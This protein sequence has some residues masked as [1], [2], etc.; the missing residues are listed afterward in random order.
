VSILRNLSSTFVPVRESRETSGTIA[1]NNQE[2]VLDV[3]GD[4]NVL[5]SMVPS[6]FIGTID[7]TG[8][9]DSTGSSYHSIP[10]YSYA[11]G[12]VGGT[13]PIAGQPLITD[14]LVAANTL[15]Q[16]VIPCGQLKKV[17]VRTLAYTSG[18]AVFTLRSDSNAPLNTE[19]DAKAATLAGTNT[20]ASGSAVTLTLAAV[21]GFRHVLMSVHIVRS[22]TA[23]LTA[24]ATPVTV[25]TTNIPGNPIFTFGSD[26]AA[27]GIDKDMRLDCGPTGLATTTIN[28]ATTI[29]APAYT[30]VIWRINAVYRLGL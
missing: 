2:V 13:I 6:A 28:T 10:A 26:V 18:S 15:R 7:F 17:R 29:V 20:A 22:A 24:S 21:A 16:Y 11:V 3:N 5:V 4:S 27:Q 25:T 19:I 30:G 14:A 1:G 9:G 12:N 23:A 8:T